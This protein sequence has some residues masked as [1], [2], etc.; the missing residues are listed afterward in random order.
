MTGGLLAS[1]DLDDA[2]RKTFENLHAAE[3]DKPA[4]IK[5]VRAV[6]TLVRR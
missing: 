2:K 6:K 4:Q 5:S 3:Q 1:A